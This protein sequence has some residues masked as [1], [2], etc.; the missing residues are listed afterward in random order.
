MYLCTGTY[1]CIVYTYNVLEPAIVVGS[2]G[3]VRVADLLRRI[4]QLAAAAGQIAG[5]Q[6]VGEAG[7]IQPAP[8]GSLVIGRYGPVSRV[9]NRN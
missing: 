4:G 8:G 2:E 1:V 3:G 9:G 6:T 5:R 7:R